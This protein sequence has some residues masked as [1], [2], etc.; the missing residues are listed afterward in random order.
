MSVLEGFLL[1]VSDT[2]IGCTRGGP[3]DVLGPFCS[4]KRRHGS[5]LTDRD[6]MTQCYFYEVLWSLHTLCVRE[7]L[8][9]VGTLRQSLPIVRRINYVFLLTPSPSFA[10]D[11]SLFHRID[12][13]TGSW[14]ETD[15]KSV[16]RLLNCTLE[17][18]P[19]KVKL[20]QQNLSV[21]DGVPY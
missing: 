21:S 19:I 3:E 14:T 7:E 12:P 17:E 5:G 8:R 15:E 6:V 18:A 4:G 1:Q 13:T 16:W 11:I 2:R 20:T 10:F 9:S